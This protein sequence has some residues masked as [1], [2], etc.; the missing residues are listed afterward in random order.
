ML[1]SALFIDVDGLCSAHLFVYSSII[2]HHSIKL[3]YFY[4]AKFNIHPAVKQQQP[5]AAKNKVR[6]IIHFNMSN[7]D[8]GNIWEYIFLTKIILCKF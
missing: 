3:V 1:V 7:F 2:S 8:S 5:R 6:R 4:D